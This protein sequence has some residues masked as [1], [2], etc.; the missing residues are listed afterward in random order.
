MFCLT[1]ILSSQPIDIQATA[2]TGA[3]VRTRPL[4]LVSEPLPRFLSVPAAIATSVLITA[5]ASLYLVPRLH[6]A[7]LLPAPI[8]AVAKLP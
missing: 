5:A 2:F 6:S 1:T 8:S 4:P 7:G 3:A